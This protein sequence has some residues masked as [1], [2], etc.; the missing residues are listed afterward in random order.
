MLGGEL[1]PHY[2]PNA[3]SKNLVFF[4]L[5]VVGQILYFFNQGEA[6]FVVILL[7]L[8]VWKKADSTNMDQDCP[9]IIKF[10]TFNNTHILYIKRK[11]I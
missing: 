4:I 7:I 5:D 10:S 1:S 8:I 6:L 9:K 11:G 2:T 3:S